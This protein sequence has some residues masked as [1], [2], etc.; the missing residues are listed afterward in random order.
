VVQRRWRDNSL[1]IG[2]NKQ[3]HSKNSK[4]YGHACIQLGF[5]FNVVQ[6]NHGFCI[7]QLG[8]VYFSE[9]RCI[10]CGKCSE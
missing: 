5:I 4:A 2:F 8:K 7:E 3:G 9:R 10:E 1:G 6:M